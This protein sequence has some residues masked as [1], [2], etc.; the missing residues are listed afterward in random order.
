MRVH[1]FVRRLS[2]VT[3]SDRGLVPEWDLGDR[4][5]KALKASRTSVSDMA[6]F[7]GVHRNTVNSY[8]S[9]RVQIRKA[10]L[11]LWAQRTGVDLDWLRDGQRAVDPSTD[12][13]EADNLPER[14]TGG[15]LIRRSAKATPSERRPREGSQTKDRPLQP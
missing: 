14:P 7:L 9:G 4:L 5:T 3:D 1:R 8:A 15:T 12:H 11:M 10:H 6:D 13:A 2:V